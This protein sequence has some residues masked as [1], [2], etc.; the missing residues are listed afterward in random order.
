MTLKILPLRTRS[1]IK[2]I[3]EHYVYPLLRQPVPEDLDARMPEDSKGVCAVVMPGNRIVG[4]VHVSGDAV[5]VLVI[6]ET[7]NLARV[8]YALLKAAWTLNNYTLSWK[9]SIVNGVAVRDLLKIVS[10]RFGI[11][12]RIHKTTQP[13]H[14]IHEYSFLLPGAHF[15]HGEDH[16]LCSE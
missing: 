9:M 15:I 1:H 6:N 7:E 2:A 5:R 16:P 12:D 14:V 3:V 4:C 8:G 10:A 11:L 13:T